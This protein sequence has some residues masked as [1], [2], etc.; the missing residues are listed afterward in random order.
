MDAPRIDERF[1]HLLTMLV[2]ARG[3][4]WEAPTSDDVNLTTTEMA[5]WTAVYRGISTS[6]EARAVLDELIHADD[7]VH[8]DE[9]LFERLGGMATSASGLSYVQLVQEL[10]IPLL[11]DSL[12][13]DPEIRAEHE[14]RLAT[15]TA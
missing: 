2:R 4:F 12:L 9:G 13:L 5:A 6:A 10:T 14:R 7:R 3:D 15:A 8:A 11:R 1:P